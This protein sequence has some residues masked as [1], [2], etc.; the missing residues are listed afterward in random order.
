MSPNTDSLPGMRFGRFA[1][2]R[3]VSQ[4][5]R[6]PP[7]SLCRAGAR[8]TAGA[9][10]AGARGARHRLFGRCLAW[11]CLLGWSS[12]AAAED[13]PQWRG[14]E[15]NGV[16]AQSP[17]LAEAWP[18]GGPRRVWQ[19][20]ALMDDGKETGH[21]SPA[22]ASGR[23]YL[24][25]NWVD[26][27]A[28]GGAY[29]EVA[30]LNAGSGAVLWQAVYP[31]DQGGAGV[32]AQGSTPCV[33]DGRVYVAG[34]NRAYC[35]DANHGQ[36]LWQQPIDGPYDGISC[37]CAVVDGIA[38]F[39]CKGFHG[40]DARTGKIRW[41]RPEASGHWNKEGQWGAYTSPVLWRHAGRDYAV[42]CCRDA[43]LIDPATGQAIWKTTWA[44]AA[45]SSWDG[46]SSPSI[47][48]D[49]MVLMQC[50]GGMEAFPLS[51]QAPEKRWHIPDHDCGTS[52]L[53]YQGFVYTLGGG[54][55]GKSTSMRCVELDTGRIAWEQPMI[56]P[57][58]CSSPIAADGKIFGF[59][60]FGKLL[61][62]WKANPERYT[63]LASTKLKADG[64]SSLAFVDGF[65]F[66]RLPDG[67]ACYDVTAAGNPRRS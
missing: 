31:A 10:L 41:E 29:D 20:E 64:Y 19:V 44:R 39:I 52:A 6:V 55:Y 17:P 67:V 9:N 2:Q 4:A 59:A 28:G 23:V 35:L 7:V 12:W 60:N 65:L 51:L 62:M 66:V 3:P 47:V 13:W 54:D 25:G 53:V 14:P 43:E 33:V 63:P 34:R 21:S 38:L 5:R 11:L 27:R 61:C 48:A 24:Y 57:Q 45:W 26:A 36:L 32:R 18:N 49:Q 15:R 56:L 42:C 1:E 50:G 16:A 46:N 22:V 30:C 58:G 40:F 37:S 8:Q